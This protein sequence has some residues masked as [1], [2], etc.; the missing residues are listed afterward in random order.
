MATR[1]IRCRFRADF[2]GGGPG[3]TGNVVLCI[4][5][6][7]MTAQALLIV[8]VRIPHH[9]RMRVMALRTGKPRIFGGLPTTAL[10]QTIRLK[11]DS[12]GAG[13][14]LI[15]D[16]IHHGSMTCS[17][18]IDR[19]CRRERGRIKD[20]LASLHGL[21]GHD[22]LHMIQPWTMASLAMHTGNSVYRIQ[23]RIR[24]R[25]RRM[26]SETSQSFTG[27]ERNAKRILK[28]ALLRGGMSRT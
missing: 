2:W 19:A 20:G 1:A 14:G 16:D 8:K 12:I 27:L 13:L 24:R 7:A 9:R 28:R 10:L 25:C 21:A 6:Q 22:R 26:A 3:A 15:Q 4:F 17:A 11:A 18:K 23:R 5:S